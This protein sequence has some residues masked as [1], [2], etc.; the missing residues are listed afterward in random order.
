MNQREQ[1]VQNTFDRIARRY[2]L[3]NR[4]ISFH[5]DTLW[6]K[7]LVRALALRSDGDYVLDLGTGTGDLAQAAAR[8][9][10]GKIK[11]VGL[12]FSHPMLQLA[13]AK[14]RK[15]P[16]GE[17]IFYVMGNALDA[18]FKEER[19]QAAM[20]AFVLRNIPDLDRFFRT[21]YRLLKPGGRF[22][23]LDMFPPKGKSFGVLYGLYFYRVVPWIGAGLARDQSAYRY[24][25]NSVRHF[26]PPEAIASMIQQ[27]GFH[28][29]K[30]SR[31]LRGAICLHTAEKP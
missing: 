20:T 24:L 6:R 11:V 7:R 15:L 26:D 30:T 25:S 8:E 12:D 31:Y 3:L 14:K 27:A 2:D 4:V 16:H 17:K 22:A 28:S 13:Q 29:V 23:S 10:S 1:F 9:T 19:F 5:L 21:A 18:P